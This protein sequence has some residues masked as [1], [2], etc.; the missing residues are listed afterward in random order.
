MG[1]LRERR[2]YRACVPAGHISPLKG[3]CGVG[4][5]CLSTELPSLRD[6]ASVGVAT[7]YRACVPAGQ[8]IRQGGDLLPSCCSCGT[9]CPS[10]L[11]RHTELAPLGHTSSL[12]RLS[13]SAPVANSPVRGQSSVEREP[14]PVFHVPQGQ[15]LGRTK[16]I[17]VP[18]K[19]PFRDE[20]NDEKNN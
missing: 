1:I 9:M 14:P 4:R 2:L 10:W 12:Y 18:R 7:F 8:C 6:N 16:N 20:T 5:N 13:K 15:K 11:L 17:T 19:R 3:R